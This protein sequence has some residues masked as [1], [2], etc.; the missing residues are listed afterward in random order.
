VPVRNN[1]TVL[2]A[3]GQT[4]TSATSCSTVQ[5]AEIYDLLPD[6]YKNENSNKNRTA[7]LEKIRGYA[8]NGE[9]QITGFGIVPVPPIDFPTFEPSMPLRQVESFRRPRPCRQRVAVDRRIP[10]SKHAYAPAMVCGRAASHLLG[11]IWYFPETY[12]LNE[13]QKYFLMAPGRDRVATIGFRC[14]VDS[15]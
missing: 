8:K 10:R 12:R 14:A 15:P 6:V 11:S 9:K 7:E 13:H 3:G 4:C 5:S 2:I 1:G